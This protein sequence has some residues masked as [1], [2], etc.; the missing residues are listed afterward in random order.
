M[1]L[2]GSIASPYVA[3]V[4]MFADLK[5]IDLVLE[6]APGDLGSDEFKAINPIGKIPALDTPDGVI[7]ESTVICD[8][9]ESLHPEPALIL[10][11]PMLQARTRMI[12]RMTDL[13]V[14]PQITPLNRMGSERDQD[15]I[16]KQ[17]VEFVRAFQYL[18]AFMGDVSVTGPFAAGT[19]PSLG[20]CALAPF[21]GML[22]QIV[23]AKY[24]EVVDP[25]EG[26]GRLAIWWQ[27]MLAHP[28]SRRNIDHY[29]AELESF[30]VWLHDMLANSTDA[31][32]QQVFVL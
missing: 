12:A 2:Y 1:K 30:L 6:P 28:A 9:L 15:L 26:S 5:G 10:L 20:D 16:D 22:K 18:E 11:A 24:P 8:Y 25:T 3:R 31:E 17:A 4:T 29:E 19:T 21:I 13:Y 27:A 23:F 14:A 32:K 7:A